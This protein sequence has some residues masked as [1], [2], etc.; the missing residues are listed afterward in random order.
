M[1]TLFSF[2]VL[3]GLFLFPASGLLAAEPQPDVWA[4]SAQTEVEAVTPSWLLGP[5]A[6]PVST[7][8]PK[9]LL[10][11]ILRPEFSLALLTTTMVAAQNPTD[12]GPDPEIDGASSE[13]APSHIWADLNTDG[14]WSCEFSHVSR[15]GSVCGG[16]STY[17]NG[18]PYLYSFDC[19][20]RVWWVPPL[21]ERTLRWVTE[22]RP[23]GE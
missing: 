1:K 6:T 8:P 7:C 3:M 16:C 17:Y 10:G 21:W 9:T 5:V 18:T 20:R 13:G 12:L 14:G 11:A 19:K 15:I 22:C 23:C 4:P 2:L